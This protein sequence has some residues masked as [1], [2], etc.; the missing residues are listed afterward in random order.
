MTSDFRIERLQGAAAHKYLPEVAK[1]RITVFREYPY[2]YDGDLDYEEKYLKTYTDSPGS[3]IVAVFAGDK[4]V[5]A[6]TGLPMTDA[7]HAVREAFSNRGYNLADWFYH[8]ESVLLPEYRGCGIGVE[9]FRQ[10]E[11]HARELGGMTYATFCGVYRPDDHPLKPDG[12]VP[13]HAFWRNRGY[14]PLPG[15]RCYFTWKEIGE[16]E[17]SPKPL[18]FWYKQL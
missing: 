15:V 5:G 2:L 11:T 7:D 4:I 12:Y 9:F 16:S 1:L 18:D 6:A 14:Q 10:R 13:L 3:V 17:E 8:G